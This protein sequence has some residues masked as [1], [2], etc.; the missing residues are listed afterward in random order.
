[1]NAPILTVPQADPGAGYHAHKAEIDAAA[2]RALGSGWYILGAEGA[3][4]EKE[5]AAWQG[6]ARAVGCANGTD[7]L[8]LTL[9]GMGIGAGC[10]VVT[11]SHTAVAT[12]AAIEMVGATPL[13]VDIDPD[14]FTMDPDELVAVLNDPP[15]GLPPIRA[16]IPV[17][18]YGHPADM[19]A[20]RA[21]AER[22][23][24]ALLEDAAQAHGAA[25]QEHRCG[26]LG[27]AAAWS[28]YPGKNLGALGD[29]GAITT[30]DE[31]L[32][33]RLRALRNYG[34]RQRYVHEVAG[35]NSRLDELQAAVLRA[36]LPRLDEWN[37]SRRSMA[38]RYADGL[39]GLDL[40]LPQQR[41][42]TTHAWHLYVVESDER[43]GLRERLARRGIECHVH[44]PT[45]PHHQGAYRDTAL[46]RCVLPVSERLA[47]TALSLPL[48][49][50]MT[51]DQVDRV[52][53]AVRAEAGHLAHA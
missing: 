36:K 50:T 51:A 10:T 2:L 53:D 28:F 4:F 39:C 44:Y 9:R 5:F 52:I 27:T 26:A 40:A 46:G 48:S 30:N 19:R 45:A 42:D 12:V 17:H 23:G 22:H 8:M 7:A 43:D 20:L 14:T 18:L 33:L 24:L 34:S 16:I 25:Q 47:A 37:A 21:V 13:L 31:S 35:V 32:A 38:R 15:P 29:G 11:V 1:M 49:P 6:A 3:A 41:D